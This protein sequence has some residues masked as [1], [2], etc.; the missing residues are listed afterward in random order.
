MSNSNNSYILKYEH[1]INTNL[2]NENDNRYLSNNVSLSDFIQ[3]LNKSNVYDYNG[4]FFI[5]E[6][7][8]RTQLLC[9]TSETNQY[10]VLDIGKSLSI[11]LLYEYFL[12]GSNDTSNVQISKTLAFDLR[13]SL[14]KETDHY[15]ITVTAKYDYSQ[16]TATIQNNV[17]LQES[18]ADD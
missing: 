6:L 16:I 13:P 11:P 4:A 17:S 1:L 14:L 8:S 15:I 12:T 10:K 18:I 3:G 5:P 7:I 2:N 9:D